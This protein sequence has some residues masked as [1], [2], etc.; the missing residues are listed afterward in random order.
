MVAGFARRVRAGIDA[1]LTVCGRG[2]IK[3]TLFDLGLYPAAVPDPNGEVR[4]EVYELTDPEPI[5]AAL[6]VIEGYRPVHPD[7]SPYTRELTGVRF[8]DGT[9]ATAFVYMYNAP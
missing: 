5:L 4:G 1:Q 2:A 3:A 8:P 9:H 6:D 7:Q